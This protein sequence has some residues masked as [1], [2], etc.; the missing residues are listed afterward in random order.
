ML[1]KSEEI[2]MGIFGFSTLGKGMFMLHCATSI[3]KDGY[4]AILVWS[5]SCAFGLLVGLKRG[6]TG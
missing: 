6:F 1:V 5:W 2:Q 4:S 3:F